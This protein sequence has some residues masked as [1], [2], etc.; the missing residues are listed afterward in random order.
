MS[1]PPEDRL[2]LLSFEQIDAALV[3]LE[4]YVTIARKAAARANDEL[5]NLARR[6]RQARGT[7]E[8]RRR[9]FADPQ[10]TDGIGK[11]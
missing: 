5:E 4:Q 7:L 8:V 11:P 9:G 1:A 6:V 2:P 3:D 10:R